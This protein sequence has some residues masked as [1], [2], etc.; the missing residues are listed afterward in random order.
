VTQ[1]SLAGVL[2]RVAEL[3]HAHGA[4]VEVCRAVAIYVAD[5]AATL[6]VA[7]VYASTRSALTHDSY[8]TVTLGLSPRQVRAWLALIRGTRTTRGPDGRCYGG[9]RGLVAALAVGDLSPAEQQRFARL[10]QI[11]A[12]GRP[13]A[14]C[15]RRSVR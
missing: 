7:S 3:V 14:P 15:R 11:A 6:T 13:P 4:D 10:A 9:R 12:T 1:A 2:D 5:R 8:L